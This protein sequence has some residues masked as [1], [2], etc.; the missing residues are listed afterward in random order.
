[1]K[2]GGEHGSNVLSRLRSAPICVEK[3]LS[4]E[5]ARACQNV[6]RS[7]QFRFFHS[8]ILLQQAAFPSGP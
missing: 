2:G 5:A 6:K 1:M 8:Q 4:V 3:F 7:P